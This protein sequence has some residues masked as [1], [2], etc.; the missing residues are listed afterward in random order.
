MLFFLLALGA[1]RWFA[2]NPRI[3]RYLVVG[4]LFALGLMAKPQV[5]TL[6]LVLLLWDYWPLQRMFER[7]RDTAAEGIPNAAAIP[8]RKLSWLIS[9]G[10]LGNASA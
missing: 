3:G 9:S 7:A 4:A 2:M 10:K 8:P 1:Y 5:I 6:P